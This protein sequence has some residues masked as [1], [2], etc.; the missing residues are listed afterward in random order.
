VMP[1]AVITDEKGYKAVRYHYLIP[2]LIEAIKE[3][4]QIL[5]GRA[6]ALAR[7]R[8]ELERL[9]AAQEALQRQVAELAGV[10]EELAQLRTAL[11]HGAAAGA[12]ATRDP[13]DESLR[14]P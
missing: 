11:R 8:G 7:Q 12:L 13:L 5:S 10:R 14:A 6:D 9:T 2:L 4:D 1:E 3:Q